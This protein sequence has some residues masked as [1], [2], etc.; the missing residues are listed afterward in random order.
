LEK[1][2]LYN[3]VFVVGGEILP[4][5]TF[6]IPLSSGGP[7]GLHVYT[8]GY[9]YFPLQIQVDEGVDNE[10]P[11]M[12]PLDGEP[13][14]DPRISDIRFAKISDQV[15]QITMRVDDP[16]GNL[17][18]QML[19]IDTKRFKSYRMLPAKGDLRDKKANFPTGNYVSAF[20]P[21]ALDKEDLKDWLFVVA[22]HRCSNGPIY[23]GLNQSILSPPVP[24]RESLRCEVPGIW[25]SNFQKIYQFTRQSP[26]IF[27]GEQIEGDIIIDRMI[28]EEEKINMVFRFKG[29]NG[30]ATL[31]LLCKDNSVILK[32][33][34]ALPGRFG[35]WI[36]TKMKNEKASPGGQELFTANCFLCHLP[37]STDTKLGPGLKGLF[38]NPRLP[39]TGTPTSEKI[40]RDRIQKGGEKMP[41]FKNLKEEEISAII[42]Y[43]KS[44]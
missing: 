44:L 14:D 4:D 10:I 34:F 19:A 23:N 7:W 31:R 16:D 32:G 35:E 11:V 17:G 8:E 38:K 28:Q 24:H 22:D 30:E 41:P 18:P 42:D 33:N 6:K 40:I 43:L 25:K 2:E 5:G 15:I 3:D 13:N 39:S 1:G 37:D 21:V 20:I 29:E 27:K 9:F 36:F 12:L 26:G